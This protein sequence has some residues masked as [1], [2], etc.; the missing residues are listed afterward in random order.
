MKNSFLTSAIL[1]K[2]IRVRYVTYRL[3]CCVQ[4]ILFSDQLCLF[5]RNHSNAI[6]YLPSFCAHLFICAVS[7][8]ACHLNVCVLPVLFLLYRCIF[9]F[10]VGMIRSD[11]SI[12]IDFTSMHDIFSSL[13]HENIPLLWTFDFNVTIF[14]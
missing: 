3:V 10:L 11:S 12:V 9:G 1:L 4:V 2:F 13:L 5:L 7:L 6:G 8:V 14:F